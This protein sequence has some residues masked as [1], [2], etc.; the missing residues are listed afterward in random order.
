MLFTAK[1]SLDW[2]AAING[3]LGVAYDRALF[4]AIGGAAWAGANAS[5]LPPTDT[6]FGDWA[7]YSVSKTLS[8]FDIGAGVEYAFTPNWVGRVEY[9]YYDFGKY[10]LFVADL[11][12]PAGLQPEHL[13]QHRPR[14]PGLSVQLAGSGCR[15]VLRSAR[16]RDFSRLARSFDRAFFFDG[17]VPPIESLGF[18]ELRRNARHFCNTRR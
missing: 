12:L 11:L 1:A 7:G 13:G 3:R 2:L 18:R 9:R 17:G 5:L 10:N 4:Y 14:R 8:G 16:I 6:L 15:Q